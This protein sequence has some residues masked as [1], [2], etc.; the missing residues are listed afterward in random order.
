VWVPVLGSVLLLNIIILNIIIFLPLDL[1]ILNIIKSKSV[2]FLLIQ[3][4]S[5]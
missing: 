1:T 5:I 3:T 4:L 2:S